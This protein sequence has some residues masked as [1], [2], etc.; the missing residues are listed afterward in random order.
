MYTLKIDL[1]HTLTPLCTHCVSKCLY[2]TCKSQLAA[3]AEMSILKMFFFWCLMFLLD[4]NV[5][6]L[7]HALFAFI[8]EVKMMKSELVRTL[9]CALIIAVHAKSCQIFQGSKYNC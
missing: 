4:F 5:S 7:F 3:A 2:K 1:S 9:H 6:K 8:K